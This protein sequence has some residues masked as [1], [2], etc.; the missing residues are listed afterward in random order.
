VAWVNNAHFVWDFFGSL[1]R[2]LEPFLGG[3][4]TK[5]TLKNKWFFK[6]F[7]NAGFWV[8]GAFGCSLGPLFVLSW[9]DPDL[10]FVSK[11]NPNVVQKN[12]QRN[13]EH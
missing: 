4:W 13:K 9:A 6:V 12:P 3:L 7:A 8:F 10:K 11:K 2:P 5:K 1:H